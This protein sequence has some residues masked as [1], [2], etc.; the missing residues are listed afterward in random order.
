MKSAEVL[1]GPTDG[2]DV[3]AWIKRDYIETF[4]CL[5]MQ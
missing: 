4:D 5:F 1:S 2:P 3:Y